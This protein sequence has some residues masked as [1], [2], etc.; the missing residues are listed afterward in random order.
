MSDF[1]FDLSGD[2]KVSPN[3][4]IAVIGD[5]SRKDVQQI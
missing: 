3:K 2:I 1:Y 5:G 4:D